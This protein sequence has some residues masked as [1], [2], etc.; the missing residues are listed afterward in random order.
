MEGYSDTIGKSVSKTQSFT[1]GTSI[2]KSEST[3]NTFGVGIGMMGN[4]GFMSSDS[5]NI[6]KN[7]LTTFG[8][9]LFGGPVAM[10]AVSGLS[11][12]IG[13]NLG[14]NASKAKQE[15]TSKGK[16]ESQQV[17]TQDTEQ[18]SYAVMSQQ[19]IQKGVTTG[20]STSSMVKY[21]NK[22]VKGFLECIDDH[23]KRLKNV[24]T[25]YV[26]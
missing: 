17:G 21:E 12:A 11:Q 14:I 6:S 9:T 3:T 10:A 18:K 20:T 7:I 5:T 26:V 13:G 23:L 4:M 8:S 1:K 19:T 16:N 15:G 22:L 2:T 24:K 25:R